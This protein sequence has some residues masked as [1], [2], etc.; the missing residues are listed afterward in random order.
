MNALEYVN[1][2]IEIFTQCWENSREY[3]TIHFHDRDNLTPEDSY[4]WF[5]EMDK[6]KEKI[7]EPFIRFYR[8]FP[9]EPRYYIKHGR[10]YSRL[11]FI[12]YRKISWVIIE[13]NIPLRLIRAQA[14][15]DHFSFIVKEKYLHQRSL[16]HT[17]V[18]AHLTVYKTSL[19]KNDSNVSDFSLPTEISKYIPNC[20][21]CHEPFTK[22]FPNQKYCFVCQRVLHKSTMPRRCKYRKCKKKL[23]KDYP[24]REYCCRAHYFAE[25]RER[26][27]IIISPDSF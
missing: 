9:E 27:K 7:W 10:Q 26:K 3:D 21:K 18:K 24:N 14:K 20:S 11:Y 13:K 25:R 4:K 19:T 17:I 5:E 12:P 16:M 6:G 22:K 8:E 23:P 2:E 1:K 15:Q